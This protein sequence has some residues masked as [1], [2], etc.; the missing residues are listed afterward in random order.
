ME[1]WMWLLGIVIGLVLWVVLAKLG[2]I[3]W[4]RRKLF[5]KRTTDEEK[6]GTSPQTGRLLDGF[7]FHFRFQQRERANR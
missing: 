7:R 5:P 1:W 4:V 3:K 2:V 6:D